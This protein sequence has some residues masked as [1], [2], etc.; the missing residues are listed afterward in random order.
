MRFVK[1]AV[2]DASADQV[3]EVFA[4][5]FLFE[6]HH[7]DRFVAMLDAA[8]P[9]WRSTRDELNVAP[10]AHESWGA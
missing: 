3:W 8:L 7:N 1:T 5:D 10:L 6:R 2:V 4:R 9:K